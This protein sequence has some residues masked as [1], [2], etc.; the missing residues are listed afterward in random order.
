[1][2]WDQIAGNWKQFTGTVRERWGMLTDDDLT[3]I[4]GK[5]DQLVGK[6]QERYGITKE[7]AQ[8]QADDW[9]Q[10]HTDRPMRSGGGG[11]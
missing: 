7:E 5:K 3:V 1:M 8:R 11:F 2:N 10:T 6:L 4:G 9:L